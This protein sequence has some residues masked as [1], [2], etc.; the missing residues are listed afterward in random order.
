MRPMERKVRPRVVIALVFVVAIVTMG[1]ASF[2]DNVLNPHASG[3][4][5]PGMVMPGDETTSTVPAQEAS[6]E[7]A[8]APAG[9]SPAASGSD[10]TPVSLAGLSL[11]QLVDGEAAKAQT[12]QLHGKGLGEG[13]DAAWIGHYGES[14]QGT[15]W[16]SRSGAEGAAQTLMDR[17][18]ERIREGNSPFVNLQAVE[19]SGVPV[20]ALDGMGQKHY[21]FRAGTDLYWLAVIPERAST[22]LGEL[23]ANALEVAGE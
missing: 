4:S 9:S 13:F 3:E 19:E 5:M 1:G 20:I 10:V 22:A 6:S 14:G 16:V 17:M 8:S 18:T 2:Y 11:L 7:A 15:L 23:V 12:E 21:Y